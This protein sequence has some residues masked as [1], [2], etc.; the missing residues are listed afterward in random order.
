MADIDGDFKL[1]MDLRRK[2]E[3]AFNPEQRNLTFGNK[4]FVLSTTLAEATSVRLYACE[5]SKIK[6]SSKQIINAVMGNDI[7]SCVELVGPAEDPNKYMLV[8]RTLIKT[9]KTGP[10]RV[11]NIAPVGTTIKKRRSLGD[12]LSCSKNKHL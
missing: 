6:G 1:G 11:A 8:A 10:I 9:F 5:T 7:E 4:S 3:L 2:Y 12:V